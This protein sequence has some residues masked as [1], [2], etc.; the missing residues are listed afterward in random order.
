[1]NRF[2]VILLL[3]A[4]TSACTVQKRLHR[5]GWHVSWNKNYKQN[6]ASEALE[7]KSVITELT[8]EEKLSSLEKIPN[9]EDEKETTESHQSI[10]E[11]ARIEEDVIDNEPIYSSMETKPTTHQVLTTKDIKTKDS[12]NKKMH[13]G[14]VLGIFFTFLFSICVFFLI[15][16]NT[17]PAE[18]TDQQ[19]SNI[20]VSGVLLIAGL[21]TF[22]LALI[23]FMQPQKTKKIKKEKSMTEE[24]KLKSKRASFILLA[25]LLFAAIL[26]LLTIYL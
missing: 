7:E 6:K 10:I 19:L 26:M 9:K 13:S 23:S 20:V 25:F 14:H 4:F 16:I 18:T 5:P 3:L 15:R 24:E 11:P 17:T 8:E 22:I 2:L 12:K 21:L 1:M